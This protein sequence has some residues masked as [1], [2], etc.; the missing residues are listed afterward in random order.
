VPHSTFRF[1]KRCLKRTSR[2][3]RPLRRAH[4]KM[5]LFQR[6]GGEDAAHAASP[7]PMIRE[8]DDITSRVFCA[9]RHDSYQRQPLP[10]CVW[11]DAFFTRHAT[12]RATA[13]FATP[14]R[15]RVRMNAMCTG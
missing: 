9:A 2:F 13:P 15:S 7:P 10:M 12:T 11:R 5:L 3:Y 1:S 6:S 14:T 4:A 8:H